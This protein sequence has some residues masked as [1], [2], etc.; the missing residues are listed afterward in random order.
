MRRR[1]R[2]RR[3]APRFRTDRA[4]CSPCRRALRMSLRCR[5]AAAVPPD[6]AGR[7]VVLV[8]HQRARRRTARQFRHVQPVQRVAR[9]PVQPQAVRFEPAAFARCGFRPARFPRSHS[10]RRISSRRKRRPLA[11]GDSRIS[12]STSSISHAARAASAAPIRTP[13]SVTGPTPQVSRSQRTPAAMPFEP[14]LEA[15]GF[16]IL[17]AR[18]A[19]AIVFQ[20]QRGRSR[21]GKLFREEAPAG[22]RRSVPRR[23][24]CCRSARRACLPP[25]AA[26]RSSRKYKPGSCP[27]RV[28]HDAVHVQ[29][30]NFAVG[31]C[32]GS[33]RWVRREDA[34]GSAAR[35]PG[36]RCSQSSSAAKDGSSICRNCA[37]PRAR[38]RRCQASADA[39]HR[40]PR[41]PGRAAADAA[42][43]ENARRRR[44]ACRPP[45]H[46]G[47]PRSRRATRGPNR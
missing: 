28:P 35:L 27:P 40:W 12:A 6:A 19:G 18:I 1:G 24:S 47:W 33:G 30:A 22:D 5:A 13:T 23:P 31:N 11:T 45:H 7:A 16:A 38:T 37:K 4:A 44:S 8:Q 36:S 9:R 17:A 32:I 42:R 26:R 20:P 43:R 29:G 25:D 15:A 14:R 41:G 34:A 46:A 2:M 3:A 39:F 10:A 21:G